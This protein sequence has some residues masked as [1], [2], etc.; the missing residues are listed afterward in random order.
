MQL[1]FFAL[2]LSGGSVLTSVFGSAA[3]KDA[4]GSIAVDVIC[5]NNMERAFKAAHLVATNKEKA[6]TWSSG[7]EAIEY[8]QLG[9]IVRAKIDDLHHKSGMGKFFDNGEKISDAILRR[10]RTS[11]MCLGNRHIKAIEMAAAS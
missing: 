8:R 9:D 3:L 6:E 7:F 1:A 2:S 10:A 11:L 5:Q 4:A